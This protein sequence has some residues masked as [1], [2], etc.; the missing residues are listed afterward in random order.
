VVKPADQRS[1]LALTPPRQRPALQSANVL[2]KLPK[3]Q[4]PKANR[5]LQEIWMAA[6]SNHIWSV[7]ICAHQ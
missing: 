5:A 3:S 7:K 6:R 4:Q 2:N 1:S